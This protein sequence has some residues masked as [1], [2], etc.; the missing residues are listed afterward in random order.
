MEPQGCERHSSASREV[1]WSFWEKRHRR[2]RAGLAVGCEGSSERVGRGASSNER[3]RVSRSLQR[4]IESLNRR[5]VTSDEQRT[6]V[7]TRFAR[8]QI[9]PKSFAHAKFDHEN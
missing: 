9:E 2:V 5:K 8:F 7:L 4:R 3:D 6:K 1:E